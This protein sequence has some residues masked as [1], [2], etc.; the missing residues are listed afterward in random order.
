MDA[1]QLVAHR[2]VEW[3]PARSTIFAF[4]AH[5]AY[6][7]FGTGVLIARKGLLIFQSRRNGTDPI[8]R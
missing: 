5:K 4:S 8:V 3:T 1:A 7:P 6:A 2:K